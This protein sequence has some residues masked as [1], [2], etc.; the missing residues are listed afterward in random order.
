MASYRILFLDPKGRVASRAQIEESS[1][2]A[3]I[4]HARGRVKLGHDLGFFGFEVWDRARTEMV[5]WELKG[6]SD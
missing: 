6:P 5:H 1:D 3:A 2:D 4:E